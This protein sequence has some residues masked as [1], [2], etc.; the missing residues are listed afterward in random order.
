MVYNERGELVTQFGPVEYQ[1]QDSN[2]VRQM[3][4]SP[5]ME[6]SQFYSLAV[7]VEIYTQTVTSNEHVI[8]KF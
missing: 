1:V 4:K 6:E 3:I 2:N 7:Q 5:I 8:S